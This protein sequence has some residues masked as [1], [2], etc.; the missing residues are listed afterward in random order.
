MRIACPYC[1]ERDTRASS[2]ISATRR[3]ARPDRRRRR[4][5]TQAF[6]TTSICATTRAGAHRE[7]W[8]H[9]GG[10]RALARRDARHDAATRSRVIRA[11]MSRGRGA[12]CRRPALTRAASPSRSTTRRRL[13]TRRPD[14]PHRAAAVHLRRRELSRASPATRWPRRCSPTASRLVGRSFK[15]HRPRGILTAGS[16]EPNALVELRTGARREPNTQRDRRPSSIDGLDA[17]SQ[18]RWPSLALR[19]AGGQPAARADLRR[20]LLLQDLHVAGD[21]LGEDLRAADPPRRRARPRR[22]RRRSRPLR[23]GLRALRRAGDR[24]GPGRA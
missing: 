4:R 13:P 20:R 12:R 24:R 9:G 21:V 16:E 14:R 1:G 19:P 11:A 15:Y 2:P 5:R 23:E 22:R 6:T 8:Y 3:V 18:N 10:C 17:A 7:H